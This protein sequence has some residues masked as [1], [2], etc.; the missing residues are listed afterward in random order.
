M[1]SG[2]RVVDL[3]GQNGMFCG[4]L[5]AQLG[6]VLIAIEPPGGSAAR[7]LAPIDESTGNGLWWE[8]YARGKQSRV[9]DLETVE[10][11]IALRSLLLEADVVVESLQ[12]AHRD[13]F[14]LS[15]SALEAINPRLV[16]VA[17]TPFGM[18]GPKADWPA[19]DLTVWAASGTHNLAGDDDRAP[20]RTSVPQ[21]YLHAGADAVVATLLALRARRQSGLG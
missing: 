6:A 12:N 10:G 19:T 20:V 9:V 7:R 14:E 11:R 4:Y 18:T 13:R 16:C 1:L 21:T 15:Y 2:T 17:I 3:T 5:L 8:A